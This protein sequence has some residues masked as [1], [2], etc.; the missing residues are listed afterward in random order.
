MA[1]K[2]LFKKW[3]EIGQKWPEIVWIY[4]ENEHFYALTILNPKRNITYFWIFM[5]KVKVS[6]FFNKNSFGFWPLFSNLNL[7]FTK[8]HLKTNFQAHFK[9]IS[10]PF[11]IQAISWPVV[12]LH[13]ILSLSIVGK[14]SSCPWNGNCNN[15]RKETTMKHSRIGLK[16]VVF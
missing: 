16:C 9:F 14:F 5:K 7:F 3:L 8:C 13:R 2:S 15:I 12:K 6:Q 11:C 10:G 1:L 4:S